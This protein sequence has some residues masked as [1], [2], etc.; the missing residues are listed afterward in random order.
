MDDRS[1]AAYLSL[2]KNEMITALG[3]TEPIAVAYAAAKARK[4]LAC[5]PQ[6]VTVFCSGN[7]V[8]NVKSVV[9]LASVNQARGL[10]SHVGISLFAQAAAT[11]S[12]MML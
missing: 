9:S 5:F 2:L 6:E 7:I 8:K 10:A 4:V 1:Y 3:C 12:R 11:T